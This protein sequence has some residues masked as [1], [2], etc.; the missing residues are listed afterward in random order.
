MKK[1]ALMVIFLN[2]RSGARIGRDGKD[3]VTRYINPVYR[4]YQT[5]EEL[6]G[7]QGATRIYSVYSLFVED[8]AFAGDI[9]KLL[10][11][12]F[13]AD[14]THVSER[15]RKSIMQALREDYMRTHPNYKRPV[16]IQLE[17]F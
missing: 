9:E 1:E 13:E 10:Q 2:D 15:E 11:C 8:K 3:G 12:N 5:P 4:R 16:C 6:K 14:K 17:L 7:A